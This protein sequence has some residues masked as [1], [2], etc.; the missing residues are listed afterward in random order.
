M[1]LFFRHMSKYRKAWGSQKS[2]GN[3]L[4]SDLYLLR[5]ASEIHSLLV[6]Y[7]DYSGETVVDIGCGAGELLEHLIP[8]LN[9]KRA[10]DYS[11]S[12]LDVCKARI[13]L[14]YML[15]APRIEVGDIEDLFLLE[16]EIWISTGALSQYSSCD[17]IMQALESFKSN[18]YARYLVLFD[19]ID[20]LRYHLLSCLRY[21]NIPSFPLIDMEKA[22]G[23]ETGNKRKSFFACLKNILRE[24]ILNTLLLMSFVQAL[25]CLLGSANKV[26]RLPAELMGYG[27][28]PCFWRKASADRGLICYLLSSRE[29]EYR[30][31]VVIGKI[32][33]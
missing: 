28:M 32:Y 20:P 17:E 16:E 14:K 24:P 5:K 30:Y 26:C 29:F 9:I 11:I 4:S 10:I 7:C 18:K 6:D 25:K 27:V 22:L 13:Q 23:K 2:S 33:Q 21:N 19:T 31:H 8:V 1:E 3:R 12:M 15:E